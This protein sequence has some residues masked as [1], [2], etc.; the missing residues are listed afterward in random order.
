MAVAIRDFQDADAESAA[1][2]LNVLEPEFATTARSLLHRQRAEPKRA[3]RRSWVAVGDDEVVGWT[4]AAFNWVGG[5]I[6]TGRLRLGVREDHRRRGIGSALL[7]LSEEHVLKHGARQL[8]VRAYRQS[9]AAAFAAARGYTRIAESE[10]VSALDPHAADLTE[11]D[12]LEAEQGERGRRLA[13]LEEFRN[14]P[15]ELFEFYERTDAFPAGSPV[16]YDEWRGVIFE[17]PEL[18][19][20]GSFVVTEGERLV[21]LSL[22][23]VDRERALA[24]NDW[25][26]TLPELR[27]QGLARLAKLATIRWAVENEITEIRTE[28][29]VANAPMLAANRRL[30]YREVGIRDDLERVA[31]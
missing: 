31:V 24:E 1:E 19:Y 8:Q 2:L 21:A 10:V 11:L 30:G 12:E 28:N 18:S 13:L 15:G 14:R 3:R 16:T 29:D 9:G 17:H 26:A 6:D 22:L 20:D 25:T 5:D 7:R 23:V 27:G 4:T